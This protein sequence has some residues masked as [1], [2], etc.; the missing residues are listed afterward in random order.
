M[1]LIYKIYESSGYSVLD[2]W[3]FK[4]QQRFLTL[5]FLTIDYKTPNKGCFVCLNTSIFEISA[6]IIS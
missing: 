6:I 4:M 2:N 5:D 3:Q 1:D